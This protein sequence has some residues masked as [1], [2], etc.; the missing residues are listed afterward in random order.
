MSLDRMRFLPA[1][2]LAAAPA[3][4]A[5]F[6]SNFTGWT[7]MNDCPVCDTTVSFSVWRTEGDSWADDF[8]VPVTRLDVGSD[9]DYGA[10]YVYL[11]Q[12]ANTDYNADGRFPPDEPIRDFQVINHADSPLFTSGGYLHAVFKDATGPVQGLANGN[13][14]LAVADFAGDAY[15]TDG[16]T[17][18]PQEDNKPDA[19]PDGPRNHT[20]ASD[21]RPNRSGVT[22][23]SLV[24][25]SGFGR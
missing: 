22:G 9:P 21:H 14:T 10:P 6:L 1:L 24:G 25:D 23:I 8:G 13:I 3:T 5:A 7:E 2:L 18:A 17:T 16:D 4:Q 12:I 20:P 11:Y 19:V 15:D